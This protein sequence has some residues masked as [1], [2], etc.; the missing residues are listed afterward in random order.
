MIHVSFHN[1][2]VGVQPWTADD[3]TTGRALVITDAGIVVTLPLDDA[4][5]REVAGELTGGIVVA[6]NGSV[7]PTLTEN[8]LRQERS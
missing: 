2:H 3:G 5:C 6:R 8:I 1:A 7:P 4:A